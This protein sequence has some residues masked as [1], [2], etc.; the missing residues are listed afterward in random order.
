MEEGGSDFCTHVAQT[1]GPFTYHWSPHCLFSLGCPAY[2]TFSY[3]WGQPRP[4]QNT[5]FLNGEPFPVLDSVYQILEALCDGSVK[6]PTQWCWIDSINQADQAERVSQVQLMS[7]IYTEC[8]AAIIWLGARTG[9]SGA[10]MDF[11]QTLADN[12]H[13]VANHHEVTK[14]RSIPPSVHPDLLSPAKWKGVEELLSRPWFSRVWT[15]QELVLPRLVYF[16]CGDKSISERTMEDAIYATW[17]CNPPQA[18]I[19][20]TVWHAVWNRIRLCWCSGTRSAD[21]GDITIGAHPIP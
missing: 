18:W 12:F 11:L 5:I 3:V 4:N 13:A 15:L 16:F 7:H 20:P 19:A 14:V 10:A 9:T 21:S 1:T 8:S 6:M 2:T 17:V